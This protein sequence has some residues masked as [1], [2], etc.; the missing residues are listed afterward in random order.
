V[1]KRAVPTYLF[2][3]SA[4]ISQCIAVVKQ[5]DIF[6]GG[7][8]RPSSLQVA[9]GGGGEITGYDVIEYMFLNHS[10]LYIKCF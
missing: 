8:A 9:L 3:S 7:P 6:L 1:E 4:S 2:A 10:L 5:A